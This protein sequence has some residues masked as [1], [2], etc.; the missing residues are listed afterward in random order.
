[1]VISS[2]SF[3]V[4]LREF[5]I[6]PSGRNSQLEW[7]FSAPMLREAYE[8]CVDSKGE[9]KFSYI[10]GILKKWYAQGIK[11]PEE[12]KASESAKQKTARTQQSSYD[13]NELDKI[14]T[15]DFID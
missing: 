7:K 12:L 14:D 2:T 10:D 8:R 3:R 6:A 11:N 1:M 15:L 13:I 9:M 5:S 4:V